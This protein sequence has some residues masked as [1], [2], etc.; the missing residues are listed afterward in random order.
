MI[1]DRR[2]WLKITAFVPFI[3]SGGLK[4]ALAAEP[5]RTRPQS[6]RPI[7]V[8]L[9]GEDH[10]VS[11]DNNVKEVLKRRA[12][13]N[14]LVL[15]LEG[16]QRGRE[17]QENLTGLNFGYESPFPFLY[18]IVLTGHTEHFSTRN[19][20]RP[21]TYALARPQLLCAVSTS[22]T[23]TDS[24][25]AMRASLSA[26]AKNLYDQIT[27][28]NIPASEFATLFAG[29]DNLW[30]EFYDFLARDLTTKAEQLPAETRPDIKVVR[31]YLEDSTNEQKEESMITAIPI[32]W[33]NT[34]CL[35]N[36]SQIIEIARQRD[37]DAY[38]IIGSRHVPNLS[39]QI[40][41]RSLTGISFQ[42]FNSVQEYLR[43]QVEAL[44]SKIE[45]RD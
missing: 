16:Y 13:N 18:S 20:N 15:G 19:F 5:A 31:T 21:A 10:L 29:N 45:R 34:M 11:L 6:A 32:N 25:H 14:E 36:I 35:P 4:R 42:S 2:A 1:V 40:R 27:G 3:F 9:I 24:W 22:R 7:D 33:R 43:N 38:F 30:R 26:R 8:Y 12:S 28:R 39:A 41:A 17:R 37:K 44:R 23:G